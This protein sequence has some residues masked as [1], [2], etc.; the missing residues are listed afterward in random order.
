MY[1]IY[2]HTFDEVTETHSFLDEDYANN[3]FNLIIHAEDCKSAE[4]CNGLT[5]EVLAV[6]EKEN[7]SI[8]VECFDPDFF[9]NNLSDDVEEKEEEEDKIELHEITIDDLCAL[10]DYFNNMLKG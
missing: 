10:A 2:A 5:G 9:F 6:M 8:K 4:F 7:G 3:C 1:T